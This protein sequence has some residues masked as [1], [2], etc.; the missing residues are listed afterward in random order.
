MV[1][2]KGIVSVKVAD[3]A[4]RLLLAQFLGVACTA[5]ID[6][7]DAVLAEAYFYDQGSAVPDMDDKDRA[8]AADEIRERAAV[9]AQRI[10]EATLMLDE[11]DLEAVEARAALQAREVRSGDGNSAS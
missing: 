8:L 10:V 5:E 11:A 7:T 9:Y 4:A 3:R 1:N 6:M 2:H